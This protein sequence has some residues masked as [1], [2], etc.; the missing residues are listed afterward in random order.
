[1]KIV[2]ELR[3]SLS[4]SLDS[5]GGKPRNGID[6]GFKIFCAIH[7]NRVAD[8]FLALKGDGRIYAARMLIRPAMEAMFKLLAVKKEPSLLFRIACYEHG[9]R[10]FFSVKLTD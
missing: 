3:D 7:I 4:K 9:L 8:G 6:D 5:L 10:K 1:M 2:H